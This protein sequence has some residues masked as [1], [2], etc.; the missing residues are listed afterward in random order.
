MLFVQ[1]YHV[2]PL[3]PVSGGDWAG[4]EGLQP[5]LH[6]R[7]MR[8]AGGGRTELLVSA[9]APDRLHCCVVVR[10]GEGPGLSVG[11]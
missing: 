7:V 4:T 1:R 3:S 9:A 11:L 10:C 2:S 8:R 6:E 5:V